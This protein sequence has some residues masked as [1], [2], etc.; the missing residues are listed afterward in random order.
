MHIFI[1]NLIH[2]LKLDIY[3]V[4][5]ICKSVTLFL[6]KYLKDKHIWIDFVCKN[7]EL[8]WVATVEVVHNGI[9]TWKKNIGQN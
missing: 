4:A 8:L 7:N 5:M 3:S 6:Y 9:K 2:I 1:K